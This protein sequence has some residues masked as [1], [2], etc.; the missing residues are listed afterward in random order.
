VKTCRCL[1]VSNLQTV[2]RSGV[3]RKER[4]AKTYWPRG[5][6]AV[7]DVARQ[8]DSRWLRLGWLARAALIFGDLAKALTTVGTEEHG[9]S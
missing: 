5:A 8:N 4:E 2:C 7:A 9:G 1:Q 6:T 3:F